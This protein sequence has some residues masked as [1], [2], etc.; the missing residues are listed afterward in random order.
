ME[1]TSDFFF[2]LK[3]GNFDQI[4][5]KPECKALAISMVISGEILK[6][7]GQ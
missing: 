2:E 1:S 5:D 4:K 7:A 6:F 3:N